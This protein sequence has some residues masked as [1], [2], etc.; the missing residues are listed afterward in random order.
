MEFWNAAGHVDSPV[1]V[2]DESMMP[3][4]ERDAVFGAGRAVVG[5]MDYMMDIAPAGWY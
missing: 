3:A 2:V 5:P 4:A 1:G